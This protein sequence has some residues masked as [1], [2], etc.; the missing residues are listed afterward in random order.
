MQYI[1]TTITPFLRI[2]KCDNKT[3]IMK[4]SSTAL[5]LSSRGYP[6]NISELT[7]AQWIHYLMLLA[8]Y[9]RNEITIEGFKE[10]WLSYLLRLL[11]PV[12]DA[13]RKRIEVDYH[14]YNLD[15]FVKEVDGGIE[16]DTFSIENNLPQYTW[17]YKTYNGPQDLCFNLSFG[18][19][20][21]AYYVF[22]DYSLNQNPS[23]LR[24]LFAMLYTDGSP[25]QERVQA[26]SNI[27]EYVAFSSYVFFKSVIQHISTQAIYVAGDELP[28]YEVFD[29]AGIGDYATGI[30][31]EE[32]LFKMA[33]QF[34]LS[35][36]VES[37]RRQNVYD[38]LR[39]IWFRM[40]R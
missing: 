1:L 13:G 18:T 34:G 35:E 7:P 27:P 39:F 17:N 33:E 8:R 25:L 40:G 19:F 4:N 15:G 26:L 31:Q 23:A 28:L 32:V 29:A 10:D 24:Y 11:P 20:L 3:N 14:D 9:Q 16:I 38:V 6:Q 2:N 36:E 30:S 37:I 22:K 5:S 21:S 12:S